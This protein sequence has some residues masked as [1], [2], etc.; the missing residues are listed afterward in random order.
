MS[1]VASLSVSQATVGMDAESREESRP[2]PSRSQGRVGSV[3]CCCCCCYCCAV[4]TNKQTE[5]GRKKNR[6]RKRIGSRFARAGIWARGLG[7]GVL[8]LHGRSTGGNS[9]SGILAKQPS[10]D[11]LLPTL[12]K[13]GCAASVDAC[14][15][16]RG[17]CALLQ[18]LKSSCRPGTVGS[19]PSA[20]TFAPAVDGDAGN[21]KIERR[22]GALHWP[23][24]ELHL[25]SADGNSALSLALRG[26]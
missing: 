4:A 20:A 2:C 3:A 21:A 7:L 23:G 26:R 8:C 14:G 22:F 25:P 10:L 19:V 12:P 13:A 18:R 17:G 16:K 5:S 15:T 24:G 11:L 9:I 6:R 1:G